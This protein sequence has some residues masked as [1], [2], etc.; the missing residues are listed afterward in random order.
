MADV[1]RT[2]L[3]ATTKR[4][5]T[6]IDPDGKSVVVGPVMSDAKAAEVSARLNAQGFLALSVVPAY[7][8]PDL[9]ALEH[10]PVTVNL[11]EEV[12]GE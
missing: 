12:H 2:A 7:P 1:I 6:A 11:P 8:L 5:V 4:M 3:G 9:T 10:R